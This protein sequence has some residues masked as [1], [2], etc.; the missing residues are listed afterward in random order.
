MGQVRVVK[1]TTENCKYS[2]VQVLTLYFEGPPTRKQIL[3]TAKSLRM[4]HR[5]KPNLASKNL[6]IYVTTENG[7]T[8]VQLV[9]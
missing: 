7:L 3:H 1:S 2:P 6:T 8:K 9:D 4:A 5:I